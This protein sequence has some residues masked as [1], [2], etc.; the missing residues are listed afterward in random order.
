MSSIAET[1]M[2]AVLARLQGSPPVIANANIRRQH[3]TVVT[4]AEAPAVHLIDGTDTPTPAKNDCRTDRSKAF[5]VSIFVRDDA[6]YEAADPIMVEINAR[7]DPGAADYTAYGAGIALRQGRITVE[8]EIA[9]GDALRVDMEF[10]FEYR[11]AGW[12]LA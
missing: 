3:R 4:R 11:T 2:Q 12:T 6:G 7:L 1:L 8:Q 10:T 5:T 9:D